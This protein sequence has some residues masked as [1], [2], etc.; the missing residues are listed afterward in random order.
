LTI[1]TDFNFCEQLSDLFDNLLL[2]GTNNLV[3][4][5]LSNDDV[6]HIDEHLQDILSRYNLHQ[7]VVDSHV[8]GNTLDLVIVPEQCLNTL[9][10]VIVPEQCLNLVTKVKIESLSFT[11]HS[12]VRCRIGGVQ[13]DQQPLIQYSF[14]CIK[15]MDIVAFHE[16]MGQSSLFNHSLTALPVDSFVNLLESEV[17]RILDTRVPLQTKAKRL[18]SHDGRHLSNAAQIVNRAC[19][20]SHLL[21]LVQ[22]LVKR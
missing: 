17:T 7:L 5:D 12:F 10:L 22:L 19:R 14:H 15:Q 18:V 21:Q 9:D 3:C 20:R 1:S 6:S 8:D 13:C 16:D 2:S 4:G 11:D